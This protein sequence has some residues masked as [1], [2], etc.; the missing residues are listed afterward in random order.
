MAKYK[1]VERWRDIPGYEDY[2]QISTYGRVLAKFRYVQ[3]TD[4]DGCERWKRVESH[5]LNDK[6]RGKG[7]YVSV[8]LRGSDYFST[9]RY[10]VH[11]LV[12]MA[13]LPNPDNLPIINHKDENPSNNHVDNLEWCTYQYNTT[14]GTAQERRKKTLSETAKA[15][16]IAKEEARTAH[17]LKR[18]GLI[19]VFKIDGP[20]VGDFKT[21]VEAKI[22]L[23]IKIKSNHLIEQCLAEERES[24]YGYEWF[25]E[26][27]LLKNII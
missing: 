5:L 10:F 23:G 7:G 24:A 15:K 19:V 8:L 6:K 12:A 16:A 17:I 11:R 21:M 9:K 4:Q 3:Y 22:A 2:Y 25:Y 13:F 20:H 14:Y 27:E 1:K 26:K 18:K